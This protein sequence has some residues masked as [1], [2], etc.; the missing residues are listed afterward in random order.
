ME[1]ID[2]L[3]AV[4]PGA[5]EAAAGLSGGEPHGVAECWGDDASPVQPPRD[6]VA[7]VEGARD[8][9][10]VVREPGCWRG[11]VGR[12]RVA[13]VARAGVGAGGGSEERAV[14]SVWRI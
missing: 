9:P 2:S 10:G 3:V 14:L 5:E 13:A 12:C 7:P 1:R 6:V 11:A 4:V 8:V